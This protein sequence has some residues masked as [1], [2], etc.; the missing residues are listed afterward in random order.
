M[1]GPRVFD[2]RDGLSRTVIRDL[3][4]IGEIMVAPKDQQTCALGYW[5]DLPDPTR[6]DDCLRVVLIK[7]GSAGGFT[8]RELVLNRR[9]QGDEAWRRFVDLLRPGDVLSLEAPPTG[10]PLSL[11][12]ANRVGFDAWVQIES[13]RRDLGGV[14]L[15]LLTERARQVLELAQAEARR[16][17]HNYV[18]T[19]HLLLG[20][21]REGRGVAAI[22]LLELGVELDTVRS[23][24]EFIIGRGDRRVTGEVGLTPRAKAVLSLATD[25]ARR[26]NHHSIGTEHLLL[27]LLLEGQGIGPG[28]LQSL[29]APL[30]K[31][32]GQVI[33]VL[34]QGESGNETME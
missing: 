31:V 34:N 6:P 9:T 17:N 16:F 26:L 5:V 1:A 25:E 33:H 18:G 24:V 22:V 11:R 4:R 3:R 27:G 32:R 30:E 15:E 7:S 19:E 2:A 28:I 12:I 10:G 20:L 23:R 21:L 29:G 14:R 13:P 8:S